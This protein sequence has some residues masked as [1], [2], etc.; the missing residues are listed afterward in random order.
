MDD[1]WANKQKQP[2]MQIRPAM[3]QSY[4]LQLSMQIQLGNFQSNKQ[5][6]A[7]QLYTLFRNRKFRK[8]AMGGPQSQIRKFAVP[9]R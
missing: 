5:C 2:T 1:F 4:K 6:W 3:F 9:L 8:I 7:P